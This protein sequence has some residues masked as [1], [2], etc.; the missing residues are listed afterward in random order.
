MA[1]EDHVAALNAYAAQM[2]WRQGSLAPLL[3]VGADQ[4]DAQAA[5]KAARPS[6]FL[7]VARK[8]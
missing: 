2:I 1:W 4:P 5:L 6:Y 3:G 7:L 8:R